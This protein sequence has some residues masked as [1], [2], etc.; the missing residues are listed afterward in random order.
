MT[1][2]GREMT[3]GPDTG[4]FEELVEHDP[5]CAGFELVGFR[6]GR[7]IGIAF[8]G[9]AGAIDDFL[10]QAVDDLSGAIAGMPDIDQGI[11]G[12]APDAGPA[13]DEY[14]PCPMPGGADGRR[15][16]GGTA[17]A[18]HHIGFSEDRNFTGWN[19]N[20]HHNP[21]SHTWYQRTLKPG[22]DNNQLF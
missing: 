12:L 5:Q 20:V 21:Q 6:A 11:G 9:R 15:D 10:D 18:D 7:V 19:T 14:H 4:V 1:I 3:E 16:S 13:F 17:A 2:D 8:H 22:Q